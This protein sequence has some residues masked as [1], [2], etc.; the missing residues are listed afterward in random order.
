MGCFSTWK[1]ILRPPRLLTNCKYWLSHKVTTTLKYNERLLHA[2]RLLSNCHSC[3][4]LV[5]RAYAVS[6]RVRWSLQGR[7]WAPWGPRVSEMVPSGQSQEHREA[8]LHGGLG[9]TRRC[10]RCWILGRVQDK[11]LGRGGE[12]CVCPTYRVANVTL[13]LWIPSLTL[14]S[15]VFSHIYIYLFIY[16]LI[17]ITGVIH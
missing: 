1:T 10:C 2:G 11:R 6:G 16:F 13:F 14:C 3:T 17:F 5:G 4:Q 9:G 7:A 8:S 15:F 12:G